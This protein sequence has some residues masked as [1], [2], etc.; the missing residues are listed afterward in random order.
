MELRVHRTID[1]ESVKPF[2]PYLVA[3]RPT[4]TVAVYHRT[5][6]GERRKTVYSG[7]PGHMIMCQDGQ[8]DGERPGAVSGA[9]SQTYGNDCAISIHQPVQRLHSL[10]PDP[11]FTFRYVPAIVD[12]PA[13]SMTSN[14]EDWKRWNDA[15]NW[16]E[17]YDFTGEE[18]YVCPYCQQRADLVDTFETLPN[19]ELAKLADEN[20]TRND[21]PKS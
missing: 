13:C 4:T 14:L 18:E 10:S 21:A 1:R 7:A 19:S 6:D 12:C 2:S 11:K 15:A 3:G 8:D 9:A 20:K 5:I 16:D 17:C